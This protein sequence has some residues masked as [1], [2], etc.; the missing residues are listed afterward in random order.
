MGLY[1]A[2]F[3][4]AGLGRIGYDQTRVPFFP[5]SFNNSVAQGENTENLAAGG[6]TRTNVT[7][8]PIVNGNSPFGQSQQWRITDTDLASF[9][10]IQIAAPHQGVTPGAP[11]DHSVY[12]R[13]GSGTGSS[14]IR[15]VASRTPTP[16][17]ATIELQV[18]N[19]QI[20]SQS[21]SPASDAG[22]VTFRVRTVQIATDVTWVRVGITIDDIVGR[23][24]GN[25]EIFPDVSAVTSLASVDIVGMQVATPPNALG[26]DVPA[27]DFHDIPY[28]GAAG[29]VVPYQYRHGVV[30]RPYIDHTYGSQTLSSGSELNFWRDQ[31]SMIYLLSGNS[32]TI[33]SPITTGQ[34]QV[35]WWCLINTLFARR[36]GGDALL[37]I[38]GLQPLT[39]QGTGANG[40]VNNLTGPISIMNN[41]TQLPDIESMNCCTWLLHNCQGTGSGNNFWELVPLWQVHGSALFT[42]SGNF[43][44]PDGVR[45]VRLT[46]AAGGGGGGGGA[47]A[48]G[49][50]GGGAGQAVHRQANNA[51]TPFSVIAVTIGA[52]GA[53]GA[54]GAN[55]VFGATTLLG[56]VAGVTAGAAPGNGGNAGGAGAM[57]GQ[58]G[59]DTRNGGK[60]GDNIAGGIGGVT[61][62]DTIASLP[63]Q[64]GGGGGGGAP[65]ETGGA[66]GDGFLLIEW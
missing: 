38:T 2:P 33:P 27:A 60:G 52:G 58:K 8:T 23:G 7:A 14:I 21:V 29:S 28:W 56:G 25:L 54:N 61:Q 44:W 42:A 63:G 57:A 62:D 9:G 35:G 51:S 48:G 49:G 66:G 41:N 55:T 4:A 15:I 40:A 37:N 24:A 32:I 65:N 16:I 64:R 19:G 12:F 39:V 13:L 59:F 34:Q 31:G 3:N 45:S 1:D 43:I 30:P 17:I 22:L 11:T 36:A 50:G 46:G 20:I 18:A 47:A 53:A 5:P 6:Y 26:F 10:S